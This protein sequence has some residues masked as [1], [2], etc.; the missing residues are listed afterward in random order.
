MG[1][2]VRHPDAGDLLRPGPG[3]D[4]RAVDLEV[5]DGEEDPGVD[6]RRPA[7]QQEHH[8]DRG[9]DRAGDVRTV[10]RDEAEERPPRDRRD[11]QADE[12]P[13]PGGGP[14]RLAEAEP[15]EVDEPV[16][17]RHE[18]RE[19]PEP[20]LVDPPEDRP[21]HLG[22]RGHDHDDARLRPLHGRQVGEG[23]RQEAPGADA[24]QELEAE[25]GVA[26]ERQA[27]RGDRQRGHAEAAR[28]ADDALDD[29]GVETAGGGR[30][31]GPAVDTTQG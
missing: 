12:G 4:R 5:G 13:G 3:P 2:P 31:T 16:A 6:R 18:E 27:E 26:V 28:A 14:A 19:V 15:G 25:I 10:E 24:E 30:A 8:Q 17:G 11:R 23:D 22:H 9:A 20:V 7:A 1:V 29:P 21:D